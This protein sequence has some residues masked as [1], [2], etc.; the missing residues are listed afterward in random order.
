MRLV[1]ILLH[2]GTLGGAILGQEPKQPSAFISEPLNS[3][4]PYWMRFGGEERIRTEYV[5]GV[6][7]RAIDD[8]YLLNR[9]RLNMDVRPLPWLKFSFQAEDARVF[10]QNTLPALATQK[11]AT[12]LR[13]GYVQFGDEGGAL[14][15]RAGRQSLDFGEGRLLADPNWSNVG[16]TLDAARATLRR[17][18][19]RVDLFT[20]ASVKIDPTGFDRDTPGQHFHGVYGSLRGLIPNAAVEPYF[21][22]RLEYG[23]KNES[24]AVA[25]LDEKTIG[26]RWAGKLPMRLDYSFEIA[27]QGGSWAGDSLSAWM[28]HWLVGRTISDSPHLPR[29]FAECNRASGDADPRDG[30]HGTFDPLFPSTHDKYGLTDLFGSSNM[31]Y[32]RPGF[33]FDLRRNLSVAAA[34][35]QYWLA[36]ARDALYVGGKPLVRSRGDNA[37]H[38]GQGIDVQSQWTVSRS[39]QL[40]IGY[41]RLFPGEYLRKNT[42]GHSFSLVFCNFAQRF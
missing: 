22:W 20:G 27:G 1:R 30:R 41:G 17:G 38:V 26:L 11:N 23:L 31:M 33:Q 2:I 13:L 8:R 24:G 34:Y 28:G 25:R 39:T 21:F 14:S 3:T 36:S 29:V 15:L 5:A 40:N 37:T 4:L 6:G 9:L 42:D 32:V 10:G 18:L 12:D 35:N 7:F 19:F 16:R